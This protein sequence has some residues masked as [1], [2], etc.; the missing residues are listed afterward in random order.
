MTIVKK[1]SNVFCEQSIFEGVHL[2]T[3]YFDLRQKLTVSAAS[4]G[5]VNKF[6][7]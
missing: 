5:I 4:T 2:C 3:L 6:T 1:A 7:E